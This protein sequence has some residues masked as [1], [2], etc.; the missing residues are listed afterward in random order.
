MLPN[1]KVAKNTSDKINTT[2][3][4]IDASFGNALAAVYSAEALCRADTEVL[5][6]Q[7]SFSAAVRFK[8]VFWKFIL[9]TGN[10]E[11]R[12]WADGLE[13]KSRQETAYMLDASHIW[14]HNVLGCFVLAS[15][16][17]VLQHK[18]EVVEARLLIFL[19]R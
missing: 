13:L 5:H 4:L 15:G 11:S 10:A 9:T 17:F 12:A 16:I 1:K 3:D 18:L 2:F 6:I 19:P 7:Q 8:C 14:L